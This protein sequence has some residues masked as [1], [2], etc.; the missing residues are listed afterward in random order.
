M[1]NHEIDLELH[2]PDV[3]IIS[4]KTEDREVRQ[5]RTAKQKTRIVKHKTQVM[6]AET[7][8]SQKTI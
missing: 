3:P 6:T 4:E 1:S 2:R 7:T 5:T 8:P